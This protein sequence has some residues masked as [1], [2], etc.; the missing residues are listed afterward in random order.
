MV[1]LCA[2]RGWPEKSRW[3]AHVV[4]RWLKI[5]KIAIRPTAGVMSRRGRRR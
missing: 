2:K 3:A 4:L 1:R 5:A